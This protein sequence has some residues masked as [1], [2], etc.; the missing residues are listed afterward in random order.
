MV[1]ISS[2]INGWA[3]ITYEGSICLSP[4]WKQNESNRRSFFRFFHL[5]RLCPPLFQ[6]SSSLALNLLVV[7]PNTRPPTSPR[8]SPPPA[9]WEQTLKVERPDM[10]QCKQSGYIALFF[11]I[12]YAQQ[13]PCWQRRDKRGEVKGSASE[14]TAS[15]LKRCWM[16]SVQGC[17]QEMETN[18]P[19]ATITITIATLKTWQKRAVAVGNASKSRC[20]SGIWRQRS[21][22]HSLKQCAALLT[23]S[24]ERSTCNLPLFSLL[25]SASDFHTTNTT[26]SLASQLL[27]FQ[28]TKHL[29]K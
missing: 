25:G 28:P 13:N 21:Y 19:S 5:C 26:K 14:D 9:L 29:G 3:H 22:A 15:H 11:S 8:I 2:L 18:S 17:H 16:N 23:G 1:V 4:V 24:G 10:R 20:C 12:Q 6:P 27:F 7:I